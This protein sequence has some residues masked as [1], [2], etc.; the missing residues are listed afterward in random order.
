LTFF[1]ELSDEH[2]AWAEPL[3]E[4]LLEIKGAVARA[5]EAGGKRWAGAS[6]QRRGRASSAA[7]APTS[8]R[9]ASKG[10]ECLGRSKGRAGERR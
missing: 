5:R 6:A 10:G 9:C 7:S 4:L 1:A 2:K 3:K 8:R